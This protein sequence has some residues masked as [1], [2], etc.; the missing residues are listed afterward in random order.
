[1]GLINPNS[2]TTSFWYAMGGVNTE[3]VGIVP[4]HSNQRVGAYI[5]LLKTI[6]I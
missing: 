2:W 5:W 3:P 1:M 4:L 6:L